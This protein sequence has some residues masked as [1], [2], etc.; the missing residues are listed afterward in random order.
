MMQVANNE[1]DESRPWQ[2]AARPVGTVLLVIILCAVDDLNPVKIFCSYALHYESVTGLHLTEGRI[3]LIALVLLLAIVVIERQQLLYFCARAFFRCTFSN[4]FF[5]SVEIVGMDNLPK[6]GPV[7]LTGNHNNQFVDGIILLTNCSRQISFMIAQKSF[8]RPLVGFL[9]RAFHCIPVTRPQ[10]NAF[11]GAGLV[12]SDGTSTLHGVDTRF[13]EQMEDGV[14]VEFEGSPGPLRVKTIVSDTQLVL[15]TDQKAVSS[16]KGV[17]YKIYPK[18]DRATMYDKVYSALRKGQCLG[19][20]PEG[21]SHD[22]TD[23]LPLKAGVAIIAL[24]AQRKHHMSV[25]I[26][27]VGLNY[28][29]GHRF[30]GRV[31]VEFGPP[32]VVPEQ[33]YLQHET[34]R[35][36]A[37]EAMLQLIATGMR[38]VIVPTPDYQT[39]Q[40]IYMARRLYVPDGLKLSAEQTMDLNRRFA[41][42]VQRLLRAVAEGPADDGSGSPSS[43]S[44]SSV[45]TA[46]INLS[47]EDLQLIREFKAEVGD[48]IATLKRLGLR[49]HQVR[50][51]GWWGV[52]DLVGRLLFLVVTMS[53]AALPQLMFSL[54]IMFFASKFAATEQRKALK[55]SSTKLAA[56]DVVMSY[57]IIYVLILV[58]CLYIIYGSLILLFCS[59]C[60]TTIVLVLFSCPI[61]A[62]LG[63]KASEQ[64]VRAYADIVPLFHR[65]LPG[66]RAEQDKL[67]ARRAALQKKLN[68]AVKRFGPLLGDLYH[69]KSVDWAKE[70]GWFTYAAANAQAAEGSAAAGGSVAAAIAA[71][72]VSLKS[73]GSN[74]AQDADETLVRRIVPRAWGEAD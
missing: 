62:F 63:T 8:D 5:R 4:L 46:D 71:D 38:S 35:R 17:S 65:L 61:S 43:R 73:T 67:P 30:G 11:R 66:P 54:P 37:V 68:Q 13:R 64:G 23:L 60:W 14:L 48:Y 47:Q 27:P 12:S 34:D 16:S 72:V 50:Q 19:I 41:V 70:M 49:D 6:N 7:I 33:I 31:V 39:L 9:A 29:Q 25:P 10:D 53:L 26:V 69:G 32:I 15:D 20:F 28:F 51:I 1:A 24:D 55:A 2:D 22:R 58:P 57:K 36:G 56:R 74:N 3:A 52:P 18:V 21:G 40:Q 44:P 59:W 42:G 45:A